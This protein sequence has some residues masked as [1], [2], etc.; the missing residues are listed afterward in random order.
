MTVA[1]LCCSEQAVNGKIFVTCT[2]AL[3]MG[4]ARVL[5]LSTDVLKRWAQLRFCG[6][7]RGNRLHD[8]N[9][10]LLIRA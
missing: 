6:E 2:N 5:Q 4:C 1:V 10:Q 9:I 3:S 7:Q 8:A